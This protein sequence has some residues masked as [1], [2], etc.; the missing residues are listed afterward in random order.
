MAAL[1]MTPDL[2]DRSLWLSFLLVSCFVGHMLS[3]GDSQAKMTRLGWSLLGC[4]YIGFLMPNWVY[5]FRFT[6]GRRWVIFVLGVVLS[7]DAAAYWVGKRYGIK[8]L[9]PGISP[10]KTVVGAWGYLGGSLA[11]GM[12]AAM[13]LFVR[14]SWPEVLMLALI[15]AMLGQ[16]GDLFESSLKRAFAVKDAGRL[17]PGHGGVLDRLDSLIFPAVFANAY[18]RVFHS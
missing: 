13:F 6:D 16:I 14:Y 1:L 10:G 17:L 15:L 11:V 4:F 3:S 8:K 9:A 12:L 2:S 18:L 7:G 5:L